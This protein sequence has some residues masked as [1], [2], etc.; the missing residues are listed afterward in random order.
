MHGFRDTRDCFGVTFSLVNAQWCRN[1]TSKS[2]WLGGWILN[3]IFACWIQRK[4]TDLSQFRGP[5]GCDFEQKTRSIG[6]LRLE[7]AVS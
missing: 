4:T 2:P 6:S 1:T 3:Q 5:Y 7:I